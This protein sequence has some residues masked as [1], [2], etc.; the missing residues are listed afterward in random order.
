MRLQFLYNPNQS[1]Q[2]DK[3]NLQRLEQIQARGEA[4]VEI[5][6]AS[7]LTAK[8][9]E[10]I[11]Y[12]MLIIP[13][14]G[15]PAL[16]GPVRKSHPTDEV[17]LSYAALL[18]Y[19]GDELK[20]VYPHQQRGTRGPIPLMTPTHIRETRVIGMAQGK[21]DIPSFLRKLKPCACWKLTR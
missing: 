16:A 12:E 4:E 14:S 7:K 9:R 2:E 13:H 17:G 18:V 21:H 5:I 10:G 20:M 11:Y 8:E 6:D 1:S 15:S 19:E 3:G